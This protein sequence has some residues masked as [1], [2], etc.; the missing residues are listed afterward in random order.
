VSINELWPTQGLR[1]LLLET[2]GALWFMDKEGLASDAI[3]KV[4]HSSGLP[5]GVVPFARDP[6][7]TLLVVDTTR[8]GAG[9]VYEW[10]DGKGDRMAKSMS[11]YLEQYRNQL[12]S[13]HYE[14]VDALGVVEKVSSK[15][16]K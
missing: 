7:D 11:E 3:A 1:L 15:G 10:S 14:Y 2:D 13:N 4:A 9:A 8:D 16:H 6:D 12:L 5:T